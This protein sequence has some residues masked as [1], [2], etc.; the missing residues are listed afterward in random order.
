[1][2][3]LTARLDELSARIG[4]LEADNT[5]LVA[6]NEALRAE[7]AELRRRLGLTSKNSSMPSSS[8]GLDKPPATSTRT[9]SG[10]KPG[11]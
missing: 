8:E 2:V 1:M 4:V 9:R 11:K 10:R 6:E 7:N 5:R 3:G